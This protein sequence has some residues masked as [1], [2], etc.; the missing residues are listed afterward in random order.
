MRRTLL[1][2]LAALC[3]PLSSS[4]QEQR[5][6]AHCEETRTA[7][8]HRIF[9]C[10]SGQPN[11]PSVRVYDVNWRYRK[12]VRET[13]DRDSDGTPEEDYRVVLDSSGEM[14]DYF[15]MTSASQD[16]WR[17]IRDPL[18]NLLEE[19]HDRNSDGILDRWYVLSRNKGGALERAAWYYFDPSGALTSAPSSGN[20]F[21]AIPSRVR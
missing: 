2:G 7:D 16:H 6:F 19:L 20:I 9:T 17:F 15:R 1:V 21:L 18:G 8:R 3:L 5:S 13:Y 10:R 14:V 12:L 11:D 4:A